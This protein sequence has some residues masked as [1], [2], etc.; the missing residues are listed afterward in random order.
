MFQNSYQNGTYFDLFDPKSKNSHHTASQDKL[1]NVY[2]VS[3][4]HGNNKVFDKQLK[5]IIY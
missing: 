2:K 3:N 5:S 4:V 1:K